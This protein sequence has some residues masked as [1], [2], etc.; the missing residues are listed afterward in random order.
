MKKILFVLMLLVSII[1]KA[2][3]TYEHTYTINVPGEE[4]PILTNLGNNNFK[5]VLNDYYHD[6]F[7]IYNIDHTPF[8]LNIPYAVSCDS[9][10]AYQ[11]GYI[12]NTLFDCDSTNIE[13]ALMSQ[14]P[15]DTLK[16]MVYRTD[17][18]LLFSKDSVTV[19]Y[20]YGANVGS[21]EFHGIN[22]T[23]AGAKLMLFGRFNVGQF[24][25]FI[26]GLCGTLP[27]NITEIYQSSSF[28]Q[29]SPVP[30]S[31]QVNFRVTPPGNIDEYKL[32]ISNSQFQTIKTS[33]VAAGRETEINLDGESLSSGTYFYSLQNKNKVFQTGKFIISR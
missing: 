4:T 27:E 33:T 13:Y 22:N 23:N 30:S 1:S 24:E 26:Y 19:G 21:V 15:N 28:V 32:I 12:T 3:F 17:G 20:G 9:G 10:N 31:R 2:Q 29:V 11:I 7:S 14:T 18:T 25:F 6:K 16:F 8:M 5:W